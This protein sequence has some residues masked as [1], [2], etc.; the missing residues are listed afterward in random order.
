MSTN[1]RHDSIRSMSDLQI[2][3]YRLKAHIS[4]SESKVR[5]DWENFRESLNFIN[6][7]NL[8]GEQMFREK[9]SAVQDRFRQLSWI[10]DNVFMVLF[11]KM[12][13]RFQRKRR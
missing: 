12:T 4:K 7:A 1:Q 3:K 2:E 6:L 10:W 9:F 8:A 13:G 5:K 11:N